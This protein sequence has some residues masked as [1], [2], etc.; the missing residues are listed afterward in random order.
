MIIKISA[1]THLGRT[2]E[3]NQDAVAFSNHLL[4]SE[5]SGVIES[6][7]QLKNTTRVCVLAD[8]LGGHG[9]GDEASK[10]AVQELINVESSLNTS[11]N[12]IDAIENIHKAIC[13]RN[14]TGDGPRTMGTTICGVAMGADNLF[15][16]NVGDSRVYAIEENSISQLS[17]DDTPG[18]QR[19]GQTGSWI[20]QCLGGSDRQ[21]EISVHVG[22][23]HK[24]SGIKILLASDGLTGLVEDSSILKI[25][26]NS[27]TGMEVKRLIDEANQA[28]GSDNVSVALIDCQ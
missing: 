16:F 23:I 14:R 11:A 4:N 26:Q 15:W 22:I 7:F 3:T 24:Q 28:G 18:G 17:I 9:G 12:I 10:F 25:I 2:R 8:G 27:P 21:P 5:D 20:T 6:S 13:W 19:T 1:A